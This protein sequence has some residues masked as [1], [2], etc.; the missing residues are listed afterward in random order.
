MYE[1]LVVFLAR[2]LPTTAALNELNKPD[3][4]KDEFN[5]VKMS[6]LVDV[7]LSSSIGIKEHLAPT[8]RGHG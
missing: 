7:S 2:Y 5:V 6:L 8:V 4:A 1:R 3:E